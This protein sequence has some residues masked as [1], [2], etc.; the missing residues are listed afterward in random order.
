MV[1]DGTEGSTVGDTTGPLEF[2]AEFLRKVINALPAALVVIDRDRNIVLSNQMA[3]VHQ[4]CLKCYQCFHG[5]NGPCQDVSCP[6]E[7]VAESKAP[8][9]VYHTH[10]NGEGK[11]V[12][13]AID[14]APIVGDDGEVHFTIETCRD[15]TERTLARR[16]SRIGNRHMT[17]GPLLQEYAEE[18]RGYSGCGYARVHLLDEPCELCRR[19]S[20]DVS[21][22]PRICLRCLASELSDAQL[23]RTAEG[24]IRFAH[25]R[26][27]VAALPPSLRDRLGACVRQDWDSMALVPVYCAQQ[28]IALLQV[29]DARRHD[30][31]RA[32]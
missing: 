12:F 5:E 24:A 13:V 3:E 25:F 18:I 10:Y 23:P 15:V 6:V 26:E 31:R 8:A 2:S 14:A 32:G 16:L 27:Y 30:H 22:T 1:R 11:Q 28:Q 21:A 7:M 19:P 20:A 17:M 4:T 29:A 9:R